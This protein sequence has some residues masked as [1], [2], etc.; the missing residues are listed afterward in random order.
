MW[1]NLDAQES[2]DTRGRPDLPWLSQRRFQGT[3]VRLG[4]L[5]GVL[6]HVNLGTSGDQ[7][8]WL[9]DWAKKISDHKGGSEWYIGMTNLLDLF[10]T[11]HLYINV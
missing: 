2:Q 5:E 8:I 10:I 1:S 9:K 3:D 6:G 4:V 11:Y 7:V